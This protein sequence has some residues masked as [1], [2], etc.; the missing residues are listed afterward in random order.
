V[1]LR[2]PAAVALSFVDCINRG[3]L[4]GLVALMTD[5]HALIVFGEPPL[6]GREANREAWQGYFTAYPDYVIYP[7][8]IAWDGSAVAIMG[9]TTGSHLGLADDVELDLTL[10]WV[11]EVEDARVAAWR[12]LEDTPTNRRS[13]G[14]SPRI[15]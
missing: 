3:D 12:L 4:D 9:S 15:E 5:S 2:P 6:A 1:T 8:Q 7:R 10:I 13:N 14:L 11:A